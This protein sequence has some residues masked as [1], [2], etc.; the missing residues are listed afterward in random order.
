MGHAHCLDQQT[1]VLCMYENVMSIV[2]VHHDAVR[3]TR[4]DHDMRTLLTEISSL[5]YSKLP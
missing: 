4:P 2:Q 3:T 1:I 5:R